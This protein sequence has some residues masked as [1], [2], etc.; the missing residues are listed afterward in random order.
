MPRDMLMNMEQRTVTR[1]LAAE[2]VKLLEI[3]CRMN[4]QYGSACM[5]KAFKNG[6][7][8][9]SDNPRSGRLSD[10]ATPEQFKKL[11]TQFC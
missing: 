10:V 1:F 3:L 11:K 6:G 4:R 9:I 2:G 5:S 8:D 7:V